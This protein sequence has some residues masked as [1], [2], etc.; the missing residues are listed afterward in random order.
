LGADFLRADFVLLQFFLIYYLHNNQ[1]CT[2]SASTAYRPCEMER[3]C[4]FHGAVEGAA[5]DVG[6]YT[7]K[8]PY[9]SQEGIDS[10]RDGTGLTLQVGDSLLPG[11]WAPSET[12]FQIPSTLEWCSI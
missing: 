4:V 6:I 7:E 8:L 3:L 5:M 11:E 10:Q 12:I 9:Q 2:G 1:G